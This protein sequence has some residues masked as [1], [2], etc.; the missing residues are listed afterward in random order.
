MI[1]FYILTLSP[2]L[3]EV[4]AYIE[5]QGFEHEVHLNRTRFWVPEGP[6]LTDFLLRYADVCPRV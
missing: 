3:T 2:R 4:F 6:R 1:E 5:Q